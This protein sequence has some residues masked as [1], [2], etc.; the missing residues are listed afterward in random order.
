M[1][2]AQMKGGTPA[3]D[4]FTLKHDYPVAPSVVFAA[5]ADA[6]RRACW[7]PPKSDAMRI[8]R[9]EFEVSGVDE[10]V[11]GPRG[12]LRMRGTTFY[13]D[14][15]PDARTVFAE[16]IADGE[17]AVGAALVTWILESIDTGTRVTKHVQVM[18]MVGDPI[19]Q[20]SRYG[21]WA[22]ME[23]LAEHLAERPEGSSSPDR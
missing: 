10:F 17:V 13:L 23:N 2:L 16:R 22:A 5:Y 8:L 21:R 4:T 11:C 6:D 3:L 14:I 19:I 9:A 15:E 18:S 12:E 7:A 20:G 1:D